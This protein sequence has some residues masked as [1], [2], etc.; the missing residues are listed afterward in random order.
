MALRVLLADESSSIYKVFQL[1]LQDFAAEIKP[2][3]I[4]LDV[5]DVALSFKPDI[6][7]ADILLQKLSGYEVSAK[8]N[9]HPQLNHIPV[10]LMWSSFMNLDEEQFTS[11]GA[12]GRLEKPF[13]TDSL[14]K[15]IKSLV[16]R[17]N[18]NPVANHT[19]MPAIELDF[20]NETTDSLESLNSELE[21]LSAQLEQT[22]TDAFKIEDISEVEGISLNDEDSLSN[23]D[24]SDWAQKEFKPATLS[25]QEATIETNNIASLDL[26]DIHETVDKK[27][28]TLSMDDFEVL[29]LA[30]DGTPD[31]FLIQT[32]LQNKQD[33]N[34]QQ[35]LVPVE[36]S[37]QQLETA[38]K[39]I[40]QETL[41]KVI[42]RVV[43]DLATQLIEK[44][45]QRLLAEK[46]LNP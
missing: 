18:S 36:I 45:I 5:I 2:V 25:Q 7:F 15:T 24:L 40:S 20:N 19:T 31:G 37:E 30:D 21:S 38:L 23:D 43:P 12:K 35:S 3:H 32:T 44:E 1:S 4:G 11:C 17:T 39:S 10:V 28:A 46:D 29:D 42:W 27:T 41:E 22:T 16:N 34:H 14:R 6:I 8:I 13:D 26:S 33:N 9:A